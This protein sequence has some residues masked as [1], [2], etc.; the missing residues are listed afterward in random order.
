MSIGPANQG[1]SRG[2]EGLKGIGK[3]V[4]TLAYIGS[5]LLRAVG[6]STGIS[7]PPDSEEVAGSVD[8]C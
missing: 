7:K 2:E 5:H 6:A 3:Y 1:Q 4:S 8:F